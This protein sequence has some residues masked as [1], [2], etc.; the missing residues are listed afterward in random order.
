MKSLNSLAAALFFSMLASCAPPS[1][2]A[3][4]A[5][6]LSADRLL[7]DVKTLSSDEYGGRAPGSEGEEKTVA[8][9]SERFKELGLAPGNPD[10]T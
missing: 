8:Y 2:T 7:E 10:G 9:L 1:P 3:D 6:A 5:P 4:P